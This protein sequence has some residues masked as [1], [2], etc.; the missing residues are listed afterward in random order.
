M[1]RKFF[2]AVHEAVVILFLEIL[3]SLRFVV[4][5]FMI[6]SERI[7]SDIAH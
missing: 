2:S 5:R 6:N 3:S 4:S 1:F 7:L